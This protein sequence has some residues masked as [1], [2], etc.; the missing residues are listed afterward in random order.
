MASLIEKIQAFLN[1][2]PRDRV[3]T[4]NTGNDDT[5]FEVYPIR[6]L[7]IPERIWRD[8]GRLW[9]NPGFLKIRK[10]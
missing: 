2:A 4:E 8:S 3:S 1:R 9:S 6:K 5:V 7:V 10:L